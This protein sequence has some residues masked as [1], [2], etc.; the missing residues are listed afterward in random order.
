MAVVDDGDACGR[1]PPQ[2]ARTSCSAGAGGIPV[3]NDGERP[4]RRRHAAQSQMTG[5]VM[6][7]PSN[8]K[9]ALLASATVKG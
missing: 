2:N 7:R 3:Q 4:Y 8:Q 1:A 5:W 9:V 6:N